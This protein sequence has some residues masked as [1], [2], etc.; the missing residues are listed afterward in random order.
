MTCRPVDDLPDELTSRLASCPLDRSVLGGD[1]G[2]S[3]CQMVDLPTHPLPS[4]DLDFY[5]LPVA[6]PIGGIPTLAS[7]ILPRVFGGLS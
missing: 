2:Y 6:A 7:G 4:P 5:D 1:Q 3:T